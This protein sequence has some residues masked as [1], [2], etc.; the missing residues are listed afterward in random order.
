M[1]ILEML[2]EHKS[3]QDYNVSRNEAI[4]LFEKQQNAIK[5]IKDTE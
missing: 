1:C 2:R 3:Q 5:S 4:E